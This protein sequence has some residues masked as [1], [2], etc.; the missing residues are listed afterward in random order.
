M[1]KMAW[2]I[3]LVCDISGYELATHEA[4]VD[5]LGLKEPGPWF[6]IKMSSYQYR[7]SHCGD[8]TVVRSSYPHN[9][10]SYTCKTSLYWDSPQITNI[11]IFN[12]DI[13]II[14]EYFGAFWWP[15][16]PVSWA[17]PTPLF[18]SDM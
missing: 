4:S 18:A 13:I 9:G 11:Y 5:D 14:P 2:H 3:T 12:V 15:G 1:P 16:V 17:A 8:K 6:N 7:K 10:I